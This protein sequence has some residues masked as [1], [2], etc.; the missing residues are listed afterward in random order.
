MNKIQDKSN[1][2]SKRKQYKNY[3]LNIKDNSFH[4]VYDE[5]EKCEK[6]KGIQTK[7]IQEVTGKKEDILD[8]N[9]TICKEC[10]RKYNDKFNIE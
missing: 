4:L 1:V 2:S 9:F 10:E 5:K 3:Y 8:N 6:L 7:F